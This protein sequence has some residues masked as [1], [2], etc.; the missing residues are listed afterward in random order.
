MADQQ[1]FFDLLDIMENEELV[2][3]TRFFDLMCSTFSHCKLA[4]PRRRHFDGR[5]GYP[6][7]A[8]HIQRPQPL[9]LYRQTVPAYRSDPAHDDGWVAAGGLGNGAQASSRKRASFFLGHPARPWARR[10]HAAAR[11]TAATAGL[12][13]NPGRRSRRR[14]AGLQAS[15]PARFP[16]AGQS[17]PRSPAGKRRGVSTGRRMRQ[18][19]NPPGNR[20]ARLGCRRQELLGNRHHPWAFR[21]APSASS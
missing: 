10:R 18:G 6:Q 9:N 19:V 15:A 16:T 4:L 14:M 12:P 8:P 17:F 7:A 11:H 20:S 21:S 5:C 1:A 3:P 2:E 13:G